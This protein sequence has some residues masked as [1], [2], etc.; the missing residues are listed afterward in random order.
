MRMGVYLILHKNNMSTQILTIKNKLRQNPT[1]LVGLKDFDY[2]EDKAIDPDV[3]LKQPNLS[4]YCL[5]PE[6]KRAIFVLTPTEINLCDAPFYYLEQ[7]KTAQQL[8]AVPYDTL[9][10]LATE[11]N[12]DS[13]RIILIY[14]V[15]RCGS[16]LLSRVFNQ[17]D[18]VVSFSEPDIY[19]QLLGLYKTNCINNTEI[20]EL[21]SSC[22]KILCASTI[23]NG[24]TL[25]WVFKF[26]SFVIELGEIFYQSFPEAKV[27]FLYRNAETWAE[28]AA[29]A[30]RIF[31]PATQRSMPI[32]QELLSPMI[33][34]LAA[35]RAKNQNTLSPMEML[36]CMWV[37]V[38]ER[39]LD[40]YQK[41]VPMFA[42]RYEDL[43]ISPRVVLDAIF[44]YCK[45]M[46]NHSSAIDNILEQDSQA[47]TNLSQIN[48]Q[49]SGNILLDNH[50]V[51]IKQFM[52][53]H[54]LS[55]TP[56]LIVPNTFQCELRVEIGYQQS[57]TYSL[58]FD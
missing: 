55:I 53:K 13:N 6:N 52:Q 11:V 9:H 12:L 4:L 36:S 29:R 19:T 32:L 22:T 28:S 58:E 15:G 39:Y 49:R 42:V 27:I 24:K 43:K 54:S 20:T 21:V 16:T 56:E 38:I 8:V 30:F 40:L 17:V 26:R 44:G 18:R 14:S 31:E 33:P 25:S 2:S 41:G 7:Y 3:V 57:I 47:G 10:K 37:S 46:E 1:A 45:V 5:D 50:L 51:E 48:T 34:L 35:Y 23:Q